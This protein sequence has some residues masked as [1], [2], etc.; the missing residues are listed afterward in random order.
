MPIPKCENVHWFDRIPCPSFRGPLVGLCC[1]AY[2][3]AI[4]EVRPFLGFLFY[5]TQQVHATTKLR[6]SAHM[7]DIE[8][9]TT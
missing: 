7:H 5:R 1:F 2:K 4:E 9:A 3:L 8:H 6:G